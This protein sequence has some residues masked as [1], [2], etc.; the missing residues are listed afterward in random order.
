[1]PA[2]RDGDHL[3]VDSWT[4]ARYLEAAYPEG[5]SLFGGAGGEQVTRFV[6]SWSTAV[7][8]A[9][10][11]ALIVAD[12]W[13]RLPAEDQE[14]FRRYAASSASGGRSRRSRPAARTRVEAFRAS[15]QPLRLALEDAPFLGG[16]QPLYAD[17]LAFG[18]LQ[19]ARVAS[20]FEVLAADDPLQAWLERCLDLHDAASAAARRPPEPS[21][22][23]ATPTPT[24]SR[25]GGGSR[26]RARPP[27]GH[28][29]GWLPPSAPL[30][31]V[32]QGAHQGDA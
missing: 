3:V 13:Q 8:H 17:Y 15:L 20:P 7:L 22:P 11:V 28:R 6:Q 21:G 10:L 16:E 18:A 24:L 29:G 1:M 32:R 26:V 19:W 30:C 23:P 14:Y 25:R 27:A 4:I 2:L 31:I 12:I 5:P 9:G